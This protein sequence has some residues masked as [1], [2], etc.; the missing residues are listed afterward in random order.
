MAKQKFSVVDELVAG[1]ELK[2]AGSGVMRLQ[3]DQ[4]GGPSALP[5]GPGS[6]KFGLRY[7][8]EQLEPGA[9]HAQAMKVWLE[10]TDDAGRQILEQREEEDLTLLGRYDLDGTAAVA[11]GKCSVRLDTISVDH[12]SAANWRMFFAPD[13]VQSLVCVPKAPGDWDALGVSLNGV[14]AVVPN[15]WAPKEVDVRAG[16]LRI[17]LEPQIDD[18]LIGDPTFAGK[19][20]PGCILRLDKLGGPGT[21]VDLLAA[22]DVFGP[23]LAF[24]GGRAVP[25]TGWEGQSAEGMVWGVR[26]YT[27][28]ALPVQERRTCL[29]RSTPVLEAYLSR[30]W[31]S[32][33]AS[34]PTRQARLRGVANLYEE[35]LYT[36]YPTVTVAL[37]AMYL[38]RFREL[39][40]GSSEL[41]PVG[42]DFTRTKKDNVAS[43]IRKTLRTAIE[44]N[45]RLDENQKTALIASLAKNPGKIQDLFRR[46]FKESLLELY[47]K[48]GLE[49][50]EGELKAFI[51]ER[52]RTIHGG[53]DASRPGGMESYRWAQ[54]GINLIERL[55]LR[56]LAYEGDYYN[57]TTG[58]IEHFAHQE[59]DW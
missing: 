5:A 15:L 57:R 41:L 29:P 32:W 51:G 13:D 40:I 53:W 16:G 22:L 7:S 42:P 24:Y 50:D 9:A 18:M 2:L 39:V 23:L 30:A 1:K 21:E 8:P 52:D 31:D 17:R 6:V 19:V 43:D 26:A 4:L 55:V 34:D 37:T 14:H 3:P 59:P 25:P 47:E 48:A 12:R 10:G 56:F 46:S 35:M 33:Q 36:T 45:S 49:V 38:E 44:G 58:E 27:V 11:G 28:T 20:M 54:Y